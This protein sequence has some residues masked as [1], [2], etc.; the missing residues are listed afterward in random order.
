MSSSLPKSAEIPSVKT[1]APAV[2]KAIRELG[3]EATLQEIEEAVIRDLGLTTNQTECLHS[4]DTKRTELDYRL[5]WTRTRLRR[6]GI[7]DRVGRG[8]WALIDSPNEPAG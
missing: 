5:A 6:D 1:L 4:P 3:G 7:I 2:E 8:I